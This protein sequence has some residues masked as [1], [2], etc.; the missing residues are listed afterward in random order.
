ME[1][2]AA[3]HKEIISGDAVDC[4]SVDYRDKV[5]GPAAR[6]PLYYIIMVPESH[7]VNPGAVCYVEWWTGIGYKERHNRIKA[8]YK[9]ENP[10]IL[11]MCSYGVRVDKIRYEKDI[12]MAM[13]SSCVPFVNVEIPRWRSEKGASSSSY[14]MTN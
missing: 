2:A 12:E 14:L 9:A 3:E 6:L 5:R 11:E 10:S 8:L 1:T 13:E 4:W 7:E